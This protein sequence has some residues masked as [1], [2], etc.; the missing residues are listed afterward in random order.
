MTDRVVGV[1]PM[2]GRGTRLGT[3]PFSKELYPVGWDP[4]GNAIVVSRNVLAQVRRAGART[5]F[6]VLRQGKWDIPAYYRDGPERAGLHLAYLLARL[7]FGVP[8]SL[9]SARPFTDGCIVAMGFP[10]ILV[11]PPDALAQVVQTHRATDA[12]VVL[13]LFPWTTPPTDDLVTTG[14][15][16]RVVRYYGDPSPGEHGMTWAVMTWGRRFGGLM[17]DVGEDWLAGGHGEGHELRLGAVLEAAVSE[18]LVV[19]SRSFP[20]G[21]MVD[22]GSPAGQARLAGLRVTS[23]DDWVAS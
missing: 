21:R 10:D 11:D 9:D 18:G 14:T 2:A 17:H 4:A 8:F 22:I 7:P 1:V 20:H 19:Q 23:P 16:G 15:D 13:G 5:T 12:D 6:L 3:L